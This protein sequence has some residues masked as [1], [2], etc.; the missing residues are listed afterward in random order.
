MLLLQGN[1]RRT[2]TPT[3][4]ITYHAS[5]TT[6]TI[7]N[8]CSYYG[9]NFTIHGLTIRG[10][11]GPPTT[12]LRCPGS[13][14]NTSSDSSSHPV[15]ALVIVEVALP[16]KF[17]GGRSQVVGFV[18]AYCLFMQMR[19]TQ[20]LERNKISWILLYVQGGVAEV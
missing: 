10:Y 4:T 15:A 18:N 9:A 17:N 12:T 5:T 11:H 16:P 3:L 7:T 19:L 1:R 6:T 8:Y 13:N 14:Y 20:V 2:F